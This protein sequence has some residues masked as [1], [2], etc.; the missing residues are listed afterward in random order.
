MKKNNK[1]NKNNKSNKSNKNILI[2]SIVIIVLIIIGVLTLVLVN[3]GTKSNKKKEFTSLEIKDTPVNSINKYMLYTNYEDLISDFKDSKITKDDFKDKNVLVI[4]VDYNPCSEE[5]IT[6]VNYEIKKTK[7]DIEIEYKSVCGLCAPDELYYALKISRDITKPEVNIES[8]ALNDPKCDPNVSYKPM[9][10][11]YPTEKQEVKV[12]LKNKELL[13]TTYPKYKD[14]WDVIANS[15]GTLIDKESGRE[16]YGLYWEGKN[17]NKI[18]MKKG[19]VVKGSDTIKFLE[20]KL[21]ELG[22]TDKEANE[23]IV[24]WLPKLENNKYNYFYFQQTDEVNKY[25]PLEITPEPDSLIRILMYYK[26][27]EKK[28]EVQEQ[29]FKE[30]YRKDFTVVEWGGTKI[31]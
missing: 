24:Y 7:I 27:L 8:K 10:Y 26:P 4:K 14:S 11:L 9:I 18:S 6:P 22:L 28:I 25:M 31:K 20:E 12:V 21:K 1:N 2:I 29:K 17:Y 23:F 16:Y 15:D 19:F 5:D 13:T 3:N 30:V